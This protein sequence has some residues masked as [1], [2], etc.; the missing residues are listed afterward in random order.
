[1]ARVSG[2]LSIDR[3]CGGGPKFLFWAGS[4]V[5]AITDLF[6]SD[7][8]CVPSILVV[9]F[10]CPERRNLSGFAHRVPQGVP[11]GAVV[12]SMWL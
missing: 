6:V 4:G 7:P 3:Y 2:E 1:M 12:V 8:P 9:L 5:P 11:E 10:P